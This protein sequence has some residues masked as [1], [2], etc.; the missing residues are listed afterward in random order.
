MSRLSCNKISD[1]SQELFRNDRHK[2][3]SESNSEDSSYS[4]ADDFEG[5]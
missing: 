4:D 3:L 1:C 2:N 5:Q